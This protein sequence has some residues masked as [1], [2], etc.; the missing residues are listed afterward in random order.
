MV[1]GPTAKCNTEHHIYFVYRHNKQVSASNF[2]S[3]H[4]RSLY[5]GFN[6]D[7]SKTIRFVNFKM[8]ARVSWF[9]G[10][11]SRGSMAWGT[12]KHLSI[13]WMLIPAADQHLRM[14][15][16]SCKRNGVLL[17]SKGTNSI[18]TKIVISTLARDAVIHPQTLEKFVML[19]S[20]LTCHLFL[21]H[22]ERIQ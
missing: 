9:L 3:L 10:I 7:P 2:Q 15:A 16:P 20:S 12:S 18:S 11:R 5:D 21:K 1:W 8:S 13:L 6:E 17:K 14:Q 22:T 19:S 4:F